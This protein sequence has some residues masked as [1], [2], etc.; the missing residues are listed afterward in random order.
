MGNIKQIFMLQGTAAS[1]V[2]NPALLAVVGQ[3]TLDVEPE[4]GWHPDFTVLYQLSTAS[5][6]NPQC[7]QQLADA[8]CWLEHYPL[9]SPD[10]EADV[11]YGYL[12]VE[13]Y[14]DNC[15]PTQFGVQLWL[16]DE[17][18][19]PLSFVVFGGGAGGW[20]FGQPYGSTP[21]SGSMPAEQQAQCARQLSRALR[22]VPTSVV[23]AEYD[24][25][26]P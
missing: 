21:V 22:E 12:R 10:L 24:Y 7:L 16:E 13:R 2:A 3:G 8:W 15:A 17:E 20:L 18:S 23:L 9:G 1:L 11:T 25:G 19:G 6:F 4:L 14:N 26:S 5:T